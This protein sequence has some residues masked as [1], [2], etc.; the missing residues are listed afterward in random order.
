MPSSSVVSLGQSM[1]QV[2]NIL[3]ALQSTSH[4]QGQELAELKCSAMH[5]Q[6]KAEK[7]VGNDGII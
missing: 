3:L 7:V 6:I 2:R 5:V 1:G 4:P